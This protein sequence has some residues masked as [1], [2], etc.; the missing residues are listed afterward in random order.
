MNNA[1]TLAERITPRT[2][3]LAVLAIVAVQAILLWVM[4]H[5]FFCPCGNVKLWHGIARSAE[6]SQQITDWYSFTHIVH[7]VSFYFL[8]WLFW[9]Q[10]PLVLRFLLAVLIEGAW[11]ILENS[12]FVINRYRAQT[13]WREYYGDSILNS[14]SDTVMMM[15]GFAL[16]ARLPVPATVALTLVMEGF[17]VVLIRDSLF[18]NVVMLIHP[19]EGI[20]AW[21][22]A[23][24]L[25]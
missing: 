9:R 25:P 23:L 13:M 24:P 6:N 11:E 15:L 21:M 8:I 3:A 14:V 1:M 12:E 17:L 18:L 19:F 2:A 16:A 20:K 4:N 22:M 10:G 5:P 7:G